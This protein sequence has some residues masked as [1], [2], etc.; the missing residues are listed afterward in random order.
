MHTLDTFLQTIQRT[1]SLRAEAQH[2]WWQA[3]TAHQQ[4]ADDQQCYMQLMGKHKQLL[5]QIRQILTGS[6]DDPSE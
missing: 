1:Q 2:L 6:A 5:A 4:L 3:Q